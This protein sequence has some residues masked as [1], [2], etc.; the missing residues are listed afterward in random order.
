MNE[1]GIALLVV[2]WILAGIGT[3]AGL[4]LGAAR[5]GI[6]TSRARVADAR[7]RW[8]ADGCLVVLR[9]RVDRALQA[10]RDVWRDPGAL[11]PADCRMRL[12]PPSDLAR[13]IN[14]ASAAVLATLPGFEPAVVEAVLAVRGWGRRIESLDGLLTAL[15]PDLRERVATHYGDLV[16]RVAFEPVAWDVTGGDDRRRPVVTER[17]VRAGTR[18]AVVRRVLP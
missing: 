9:A 10:A 3:A 16:G 7:A 18:V 12:D 1:R 6:A 4:G 15:P 11:A 2:L 14:V 8:A 5:Q 17:W 13:D